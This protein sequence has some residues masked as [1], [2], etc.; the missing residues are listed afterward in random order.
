MTTSLS[1]SWQCFRLIGHNPAMRR[2]L[3][4]VL[5]SIVL[6]AG[7]CAPKQVNYV[8]PRP[9]FYK[10][11]ISLSPSTTEIIASD[12]DL[13]ILKGRTAACDFPPAM[14]KPIQVVA[15]VK[16]DFEAIQG[17]KPD[18]VLCDKLLYSPQEIDQIK[19][20]THADV[21]TIDANTVDGYVQQL[22]QLGSMVAAEMRFNEYL[23]RVIAAKNSAIGG[24][25]ATTPK[26]AIILPGSGG[27][28]LICGTD[29]FLADVVKISGGTMVGPKGEKFMSMNPEELVSLNP[30]VI[31]V[32]GTKDDTSSATS[33]L[34]DPRFQAVKAIKS[35]NLQA[36]ETSILE[37]RGARV[38]QLITSVH[39][40]I[41]GAVSG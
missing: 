25:P 10:N 1:G 31:I 23:G 20:Q 11:V 5:L 6:V 33:L 14:V 17:I 28:D 30:D 21:F 26:V 37:R 19:T 36:V 13:T 18:L 35:Q 15:A 9:K 16:P 32:N 12:A 29:S 8:K 7:G 41:A 40:I 4:L 27:N 38:D 39:R 34:K 22:Q 3:P 2:A 24:K